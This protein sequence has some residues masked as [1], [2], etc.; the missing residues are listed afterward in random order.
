M[1]YHI[2]KLLELERKSTNWWE[3]MTLQ[4]QAPTGSRNRRHYHYH[5]KQSSDNTIAKDK[6]LQHKPWKT[7]I[8]S[9]FSGV[10]T[11]KHIFYVY[12][13]NPQ[14]TLFYFIDEELRLCMQHLYPFPPWY[15]SSSSLFTSGLKH[16]ARASPVPSCGRGNTFLPSEPSH[17][18]LL[19]SGSPQVLCRPVMTQ[20]A[21]MHI[22]LSSKQSLFNTE[23]AVLWWWE[24]TGPFQYQSGSQQVTDSIL[25]LR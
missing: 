8:N 14:T 1:L 2:S 3:R 7:N 15:I 17:N 18:P 22:Q 25:M 24:V 10:L 11:K 9:S 16:L 13:H 21:D 20:T 4:K 5:M 19:P 23:R 6:L 12:Y